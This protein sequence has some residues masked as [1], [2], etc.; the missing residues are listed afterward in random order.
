[1][2]DADRPMVMNPVLEVRIVSEEEKEFVGA[3]ELFFCNPLADT[4][5]RVRIR[6]QLLLLK[7]KQPEQGSRR[8]FGIGRTRNGPHVEVAKDANM[9]NV[10]LL[11]ARRMKPL[12]H[13]TKHARI[14]FEDVR[15]IPE[16]WVPA[17]LAP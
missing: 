8:R 6:Q 3:P 9:M 4:A 14:L 7:K 12:Q 10:R 17:M 13:R 1:M 11:D 15:H 5:T 16:R 2:R